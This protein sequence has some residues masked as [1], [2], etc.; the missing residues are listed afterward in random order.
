MKIAQLATNVERVPPE[1]YGGTELVVHLLTEELVRRGHE[2]TLFATGDS[3]T[4]ARLISTVD[5]PLRTDPSKKHTQWAAY[6]MSTCLK[7]SRMQSQFDIVHNHMGYHALPFLDTMTPSV[8]ST[9]HNP[10]KDYCE[11]VYFAY[12]HQAFVSISDSYQKLNFPERMNYVAT[13]YNGIDVEA[14]QALRDQH[15][16]Y[17]LFVGRLGYDKGTAEAI[18]IARALNMPMKLAGK[19]DKT[20]QV[21]FDTEV[22][23]RLAAYPAAEYVGEVNHEQKRALYAGAKAVIYPINFEEPFGLVMAES[24]AAGTPVIAMERGSVREIISDKKT[25]I[26]AQSVDEMI[27][28]FPEIDSMKSEDCVAR[29]RECFS[30]KHM[31]DGYEEVYAQLIEK[32]LG[33]ATQRTRMTQLPQQE[34]FVTS[35]SPSK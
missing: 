19:V 2:V 31:V 33:K 22:K 14:F 10:I 8:V 30:I 16:D 7:L 35:I 25:G 24:M 32:K 21:Y 23:P 29:V 15:R 4:N 20:D 34:P 13:V 26:I 6:D 18:D 9:N 27:R 3:L 12:S 5:A 28:R 17:L 1:G 11:D